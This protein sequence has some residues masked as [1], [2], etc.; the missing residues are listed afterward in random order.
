VCVCVVSGRQ[1]REQAVLCAALHAWWNAV[2][3]YVDGATL[4]SYAEHKT[5]AASTYSSIAS[6]AAGRSDTGSQ[7]RH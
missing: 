2:T 6:L 5:V 1:E 7:S 3:T 4:G